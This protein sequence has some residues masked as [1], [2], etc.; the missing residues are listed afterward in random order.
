MLESKV[1]YTQ[2][3][4]AT[5][6]DVFVF[7]LINNL[8]NGTGQGQR[9]GRKIHNSFLKVKVAITSANG[10]TSDFCRWGIIID[11]MPMGA[12]INSAD[13]FQDN[14]RGVTTMYRNDNVGRGRRFIIVKDARVALN[15]EGSSGRR[16]FD[17]GIPLRCITQYSDV[18]TTINDIQTNAIYVFYYGN[19]TT[20]SA[21][22]WVW[23]A[24]LFYKDG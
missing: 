12:P 15:A 2:N 8:G 5:A 22:Q 6:Q 23:D 7:D 18:G 20:T 10:T 16:V 21:S 9:V 11:T 19:A 1:A 3:S 13:V 17:V 14:T 24:E 4:Q